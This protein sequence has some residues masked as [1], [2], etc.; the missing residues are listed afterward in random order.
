MCIALEYMNGGSLEDFAKMIPGNKL[1]ETALSIIVGR[2]LVGLDYLH[3]VRYMVHRDIKPAN[4]L[5]NLAVRLA[6]FP[7][8]R[9]HVLVSLRSSLRG[10]GRVRGRLER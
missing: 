9:R 4:I 6:L 7:F 1:P 8:F 10:F 3:R 5:M 2:V